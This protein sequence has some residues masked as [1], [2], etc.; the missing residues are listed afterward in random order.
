MS[1]HTWRPWDRLSAISLNC[2]IT[3]QRQFGNRI[4]N[5]KLD[6]MMF[7]TAAQYLGLIGCAV[8]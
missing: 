1:Q 4:Y 6:Y 8:S 2:D 7:D 5:V 3:L